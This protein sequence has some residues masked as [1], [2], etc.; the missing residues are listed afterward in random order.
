MAQLT[1]RLPDPIHT[2][3][4][5]LAAFKNVSQNDL[6]IEAVREKVDLWE[7]KHGALPLPPTEDD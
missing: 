7:R 1:L 4:R 3:L 6:I 2:K 5:V